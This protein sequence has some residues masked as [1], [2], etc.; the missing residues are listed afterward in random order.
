MVACNYLFANFKNI[1]LG[2]QSHA[3]AQTESVIVADIIPDY[4][5]K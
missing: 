5:F 1:P 3:H 2:T 4:L